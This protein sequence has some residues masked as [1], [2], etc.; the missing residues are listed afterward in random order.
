MF[1]LLLFF[2]FFGVLYVESYCALWGY[3]K[4]A[5][6]YYITTWRACVCIYNMK[7]TINPINAKK[8]WRYLCLMSLSKEHTRNRRPEPNWFRFCLF[9]RTQPGPPLLV[10]FAWGTAAFWGR[11][12]DLREEPPGLQRT[13]ADRASP[14]KL[15]QPCSLSTLWR[16][17]R[18]VGGLFLPWS[19]IILIKY[20]ENP[21][22]IYLFAM[23]VL[24]SIV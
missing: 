12:S 10:R 9:L 13:W 21:T 3:E 14:A 5:F 7:N 2:Y 4:R 8:T 11:T 22:F 17:P 23:E 1:G 20:G 19:L 6:L 18:H 16:V 15:A 24:C